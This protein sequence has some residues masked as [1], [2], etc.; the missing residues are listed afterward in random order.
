MAL[1]LN[2][3][4]M[5][6]FYMVAVHEG[7]RNAAKVLHVSP[8][9]VSAQVKRFEESVG[10]AL[11]TRVRGKL[12]LTEHGNK[13]FPEVERIFSQA[14][15]LEKHIHFLQDEHKNECR[16]GGHYMHMQCIIPKLMPS[17]SNVKQQCSLQFSVDSQSNI[18]AKI[19]NKELNLA[20]LE[21]NLQEDNIVIHTL[22]HCKVILL[23]CRHNPLGQKGAIS[24]HD[25]ADVPLL[26]PLA[27]SGFSVLLQDFFAQHG[28]IPKRSELFSLP[29]CR[30]FIPQSSYLAFFPEYFLDQE[31]QSTEFQKITLQEELPE[32]VVSL[33]YHK[34]F[35]QNVAVKNMLSALPN[36]DSLA[37][38]LKGS[39]PL[40][41]TITQS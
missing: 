2:F 38:L 39:S 32:L 34:D 40:L 1:Q 20:I 12:Q 41:T 13:I 29:I 9:A 31:I 21:H 36:Q 30:R 24:V 8:P 4:Q 25:L 10:V 22:L 27:D 15:Q 19:K 7:V 3:N 35:A 23:A 11:L 33:A 37:E 26:L 28:F 5:Y 6:F 14:E 18:E 16:L 17:F